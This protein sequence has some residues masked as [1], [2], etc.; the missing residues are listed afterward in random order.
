[1]E[2]ILFIPILQFLLQYT[3]C[4]LV[5]M[6]FRLFKLKISGGILLKLEYSLDRR[7]LEEEEVPQLLH[8]DTMLSIL[9][10]LQDQ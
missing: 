4:H 6:E 9:L 1:M 7:N 8:V 2:S 3:A 10:N 5:Q